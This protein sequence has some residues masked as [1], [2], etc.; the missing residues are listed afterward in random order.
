MRFLFVLATLCATLGPAL[1]GDATPS[2]SA[3][4]APPDMSLLGFSGLPEDCGQPLAAMFRGDLAIPLTEIEG[5]TLPK[6]VSS[7]PAILPEAARQAGLSGPAQVMA[8]V[9]KD[10]T[11]GYAQP[12]RA[13][14]PEMAKAAQS[15]VRKWTFRPAAQAGEPVAVKY[16]VKVEFTPGS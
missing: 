10:G 2:P 13:P 3:S 9:C 15:A 4:S 1:A 7:A 12:M 5:V 11:V 16:L 6:V 14:S 8:V